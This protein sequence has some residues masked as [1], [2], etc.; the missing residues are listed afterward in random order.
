MEMFERILRLAREAAFTKHLEAIA[1]IPSITQTWQEYQA[2]PQAG[3][4]DGECPHPD[5]V[6][7]RWM[8]QFVFVLMSL[9][10]RSKTLT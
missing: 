8:D 4:R 6:A 2:D 9:E 7:V 1:K 3:H 10:S 5:C